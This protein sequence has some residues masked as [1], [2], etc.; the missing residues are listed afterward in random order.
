MK[1]KIF[2]SV[3]FVFFTAICIGQSYIG[4]S[5]MRRPLK[6]QKPFFST[7][8][9][10]QP[11][12]K[13]SHEI[14][15]VWIDR[16]DVT[17][18]NGKN[19][20]FGEKFLV[21]EEKGHMVH[22]VK[23]DGS[24]DYIIGKFMSQ[25]ND[26]GWVDKSKL[27][28]WQNA[29]YDEETRF[30]IKLLTI[31]DPD[32]MNKRIEEIRNGAKMMA[33]YNSPT[34][35]KTNENET[36]LFKVFYVYKKEGRRMLV[37][38]RENIGTGDAGN[39]L[40]GWINTNT[41]QQW[42]QRQVLQP[43]VETAAALTRK[44]NNVKTA[45]FA[46]KEDA[47]HYFNNGQHASSFWNDD[48]YN[49]RFS[50]YWIRLPVLKSVDEHYFETAVVSDLIPEDPGSDLL[51]SEKTKDF[52]VEIRK[53][54][55]EQ[56]SRS[57]NI[58]VVFVVD[59]TRSM[60]PYIESIRNAVLNSVRKLHNSENNFKFGAVIYRDYNQPN[61]DDCYELHELSDY[62]KFSKFMASVDTDDPACYNS[63]V[64]EGLYKGIGKV[65]SI[66]KGRD[67]HLQTNVII[68]VGDAGDR[69]GSNRIGEKDVLPVLTHNNMSMLAIQVHHM[70][71]KAY[72]DFIYQM[73]DLGLKNS[74]GM[75]EKQKKVYG[76]LN[77]S[78][79]NT[80]PRWQQDDQG[81]R[82]MYNLEYSP[83]NG[84]LQYA[85]EGEDISPDIVE[86]EIERIIGE[87]NKQNNDLL[88]SLNDLSAATVVIDEEKIGNFDFKKVMELLRKAGFTEREIKILMQVNYQFMLRGYT[89]LFTKK[90]PSMG[91]DN[92]TP[93]EPLYDFMLF[94]DQDELD[95]L[96]RILNK[97]YIEAQ[98]MSDR[99]ER[100]VNA[101]FEILKTNYGAQRNEIMEKTLAEITKLITGLP[102]T[103]ELFKKYR[104]QDIMDI[105]VVDN[106]DLNMIIEG[107]K[108]KRDELEKVVGDQRY[109]FMSQNRIY[110]WIPQTMIP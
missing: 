72:E 10:A 34:G 66:L 43:K 52:M 35:S 88:S 99:R 63:T 2:N 82:T 97:L 23:D 76:N 98:T 11:G 56:E 84:G 108:S 24:Y 87:I 92:E 106:Q 75:V 46:S 29:L 4:L 40:S 103:N 65:R 78:S 16:D 60:R 37:G 39:Y 100:L 104:L 91:Y 6:Y 90:I 31:T 81:N 32:L 58:N 71:D 105:N 5:P 69:Y 28:L 12:Q 9:S 8:T 26:Y 62:F 50:P 3:I 93:Y 68:L 102:S 19:A 13:L 95:E 109:K 49:V 20:S 89:S 59:G 51:D 67:I 64:S 70:H 22:I 74:M 86:K 7:V 96:N 57:R 94:L 53:M 48:R 25:P 85:R 36:K 1:K 55:A 30:R 54:I 61:D 41:V 17:T 73:R 45:V 38:K 14:W 27:L 15:T 80:R 33:F 101:Y 79:L 42:G 44:R 21:L 83:V 47:I 18:S 110:Y 107:I 77:L